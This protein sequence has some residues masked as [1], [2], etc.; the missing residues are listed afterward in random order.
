MYC[1]QS[2]CFL[3]YH[4]LGEF[5]ERFK[6]FIYAFLLFI[7]KSKIVFRSSVKISPCVWGFPL[8][9]LWLPSTLQKHARGQFLIGY[10]KLPVVMKVN[11]CLSLHVCP[12]MTSIK[13]VTR[14]GCTL[15]SPDD[16]G[17]ASSPLQLL[18]KQQKVDGW[19]QL[20]LAACGHKLVRRC[21]LYL[22]YTFLTVA[23]T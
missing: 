22:F 16:A 2:Y 17:I 10:C 7:D 11:G 3:P 20:E 23:L 5:E 9:I 6:K 8:G 19:H 14:Q 15:P 13:M 4:T 1:E 21:L 18:D 12:L